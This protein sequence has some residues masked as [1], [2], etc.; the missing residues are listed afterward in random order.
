MGQKRTVF[1]VANLASA[2]SKPEKIAKLNFDSFKALQQSSGKANTIDDD[3][4]EMNAIGAANHFL[5]VNERTLG[6]EVK[7]MCTFGSVVGVTSSGKDTLCSQIVH[8]PELAVPGAQWCF[9]VT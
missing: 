5:K 9:P 3:C 4:A 7:A 2:F 1:P 6:Q 8:K